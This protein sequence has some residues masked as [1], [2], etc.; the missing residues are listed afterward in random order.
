M[1]R[2]LILSIILVFTSNVLKS[3]Q[4]N[5]LTLRLG[6][7]GYTQT[8]RGSIL[9][10]TKEIKD[11]LTLSTSAGYFLFDKEEQR[12]N[13]NYTRVVP[14]EIIELNKIIPLYVGIKYFF[15]DENFNPYLAGNWGIIF[16]YISIYHER[17]QTEGQ[18]EKHFYELNKKGWDSN[19]SVNWEM[20]V[21]YKVADNIFLDG[22]IN[23]L[24]GSFKQLILSTLG[25]TYSL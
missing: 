2:L 13:W 23:V 20:G 16:R 24:Y 12:D 5:N 6:I 7:V 19:N 18:W 11:R 22:N 1:K 17:T 25:M 15:G 10:F 21:L 8:G 4:L 3:Q 9:N 14:G